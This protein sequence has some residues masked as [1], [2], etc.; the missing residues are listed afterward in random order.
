MQLEQVIL[1]F[2]G[3]VTNTEEEAVDY[4]DAFKS[5]MQKRVMPNKAGEFE[6]LWELE[7]TGVMREPN[8]HGWKYNGKIIAPSH[9]DPYVLCTTI[10]DLVLDELGMDEEEKSALLNELF[11]KHYAK[12]GTVFKPEAKEFL[13]KLSEKLPV[14]IVTNSDTKKVIKKIET[15]DAELLKAITVVGNA[16]KYVLDD[17]WDEV[18]ETMQMDGLER[19]VYLR[20]KL[21]FDVL[22][23]VAEGR[24]FENLLV[25]GDIFEL[26]LALPAYFGAHI[27]L[28]TNQNTPD[29]EKQ[30]AKSLGRGHAAEDLKEILEIIEKNG[31]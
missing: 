15:I 5:D 1:D 25:V 27:C 21:Y 19:A 13:Y 20:R 30:F 28:A 16:K 26:D 3:T 7:R 31:S 12:A 6:Q 22:K 8:K 9:A 17:S 24:S 10:G 18:P 11:Q 23:D 29:Y 2:D 14:T 4:V